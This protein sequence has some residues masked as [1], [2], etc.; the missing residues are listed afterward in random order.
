[1]V[2]VFNRDKIF[3]ASLRNDP[4]FL[5]VIFERAKRDGELLSKTMRHLPSVDVSV[6]KWLKW[7]LFLIGIR[8]SPAAKMA[9]KG[10]WGS[11]F[12]REK[13]EMFLTTVMWINLS[14]SKDKNGDKMPFL[15]YHTIVITDTH[16]PLSA[17]ICLVLRLKVNGVSPSFNCNHH[18]LPSGRRK[19]TF[20]M[21][22]QNYF[23]F[24]PNPALTN[25]EACAI[26]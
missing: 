10:G 24:S 18:F 7:S 11:S 21:V 2:I 12:Y 4:L 14:Y 16:Q 5:S 22:L 6:N 3:S 23:Q 26:I 17:P 9:V 13:A 8:F 19:A 15:H 25:F 1:M 20:W